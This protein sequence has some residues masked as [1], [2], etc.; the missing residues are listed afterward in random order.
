[1]FRNFYIIL[2]YKL[3]LSKLKYKMILLTNVIGNSDIEYDILCPY[4]TD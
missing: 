2:F 3:D 1:M 4:K